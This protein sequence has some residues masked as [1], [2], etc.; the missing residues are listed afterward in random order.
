MTWQKPRFRLAHLMGLIS[1]A[2]VIFA[3]L[4]S[5]VGVVFWSIFVTA[6][7]IAAFSRP[8]GRTK[9]LAMSWLPTKRDWVPIVVLLALLAEFFA[10]S[11]Q[12]SH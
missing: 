11:L 3:A 9:S 12:H 8:P 6:S 1:F 10:L 7:L 4:T 2:A 5:R